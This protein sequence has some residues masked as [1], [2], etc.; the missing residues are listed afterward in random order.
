MSTHR[1][2]GRL[3]NA[4][5]PSFSRRSS[6]IV[7]LRWPTRRHRA[8]HR[9]DRRPR[10]CRNRRGGSSRR[11]RRW[12]RRAPGPCLCTRVTRLEVSS[13]ARSTPID[14]TTPTSTASR[15]ATGAGLRRRDRLDLLTG[16]TLTE[17]R[18]I[19]GIRG[20]RTVRWRS[21][22]DGSATLNCCDDVNDVT[23]VDV[24]ADGAPIDD[25]QPA[26]RVDVDRRADQ[27]AG[28]KVT[29]TRRPSVVR[30]VR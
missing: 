26:G 30:F 10:G 25:H 20:C 15:A 7:S 14:P 5:P 8:T 21:Q 23:G 18:P 12:W 6:M 27:V 1:S 28:G 19:S 2:R 24:M 11:D 13:A 29:R 17:R 3:I 9:P 22:P 4:A 16:V